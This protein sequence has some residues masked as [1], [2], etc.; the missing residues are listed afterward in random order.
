MLILFI[1]TPQKKIKRM[2]DEGHIIE[3]KINYEG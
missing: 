2:T 1:R 3:G